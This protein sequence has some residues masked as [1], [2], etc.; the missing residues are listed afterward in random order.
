[1]AKHLIDLDDALLEQARGV[2]GTRTLKDTVN[3]ALA[4]V[5]R[6][7]RALIAEAL[8]GLADVSRVGKLRDRSEAWS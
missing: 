5:L 6:D 7:R 3:Q 1:M 4:A 8:D 2:L